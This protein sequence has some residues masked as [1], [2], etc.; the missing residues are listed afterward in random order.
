MNRR[1]LSSGRFFLLLAGYALLF[2]VL[3]FSYV[4]PPDTGPIPESV[5]IREYCIDT[6][7]T[8]P[9]EELWTLPPEIHINQYGKRFQVILEQEREVFHIALRPEIQLETDVFSPDG[10]ETFVSVAFRDKTPGSWILTRETATGNPVMITCF[11]SGE[12]QVYIQ[13]RPWGQKVQAD[14]VIFGFPLIRGSPLDIPFERLYTASLEDLQ[15]WTP[16]IPWRYTDTQMYTGVKHMIGVIRENLPR[17]VPVP[18]AAYNEQ[19][20]LVSAFAGNTLRPTAGK[21]KLELSNPGF[22]KWIVDGIIQPVTGKNSDLTFLLGRSTVAH[23]PGSF[24]AVLS[25]R[26][27]LSFS[28]DW[29]RNLA[30]AAAVAQNRRKMLPSV[31]ETDVRMVP[32]VSG[33]RTY[34]TAD[35]GYSPAVIPALLYVHTAENPDTFLLAAIRQTD[36]SSATEI[37]YYNSCAVIFPYVDSYGRF[38]AVVFE[39]GQEIALEEFLQK[40][41]DAYIYLSKIKAVGWF[42]PPS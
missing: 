2:P 24:A 7:F 11:I 23:S 16:D 40:Y 19:G 36:R 35:G 13:L 22:L 41:R 3:L 21:G 30:A 26:Y 37:Q 9:L 18:D 33:R 10:V 17:I 29:T 12:S 14:F 34:H 28:L 32:V 31:E 6:W 5:G 25:T 1:L 42:A 15:R 4:I 39:N 20:Q 8:R 27:N 38:E